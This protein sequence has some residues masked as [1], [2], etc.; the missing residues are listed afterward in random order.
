MFISNGQLFPGR[1]KG[2]G[3]M[4]VAVSE[5]ADVAMKFGALDARHFMPEVKTE[6]DT[7]V[8]YRR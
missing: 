3:F 2:V 5:V 4:E 7:A 6:K 1:E 8:R